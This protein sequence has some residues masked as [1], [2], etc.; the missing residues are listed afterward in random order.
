MKLESCYIRTADMNQ[1]LFGLERR[2]I[3]VVGITT[4]TDNLERST[5]C[6]NC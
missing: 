1:R 4:S 5:A 3:M 2:T 6:Q